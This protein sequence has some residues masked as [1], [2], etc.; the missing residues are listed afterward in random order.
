MDEIQL[1]FPS[2]E[3]EG[4]HREYVAE[5]IARGEEHIHGGGG[6]QSA[7]S[8]TAWLA[9]V[10]RFL[11]GEDL[12]ANRVPASTFFAVRKADGR[13]VGTIQIRHRLNE[14]LEAVGGHIGYGVRPSERRRGYAT[15]MLRLA[16]VKCRE[17]GI[18]S[19]MVSCHED[20]PG[21]RRVIEKNGGIL[22][23]SVIDDEDGKTVLRFWINVGK[24]GD[25]Q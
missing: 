9:T 18:A 19:A 16:L 8:Y 13:I 4:Q 3:H 21:S 24:V 25:A 1:V 7:E 5:H 10:R 14:Y 23:S 17:L 11:K 6:L 22:A 15:E 20:N 2:E 12:P